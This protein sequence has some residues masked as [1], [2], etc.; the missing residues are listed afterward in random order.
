MMCSRVLKDE[1]T[2][3]HGRSTW[4]SSAASTPCW[5]AIERGLDWVLAPPAPDPGRL[6]RHAVA[7]PSCCSSSSPKGFF[8]QQDTGVIVRR[9]RGRAGH[10]LRRDAK[11]QLAQWPRSSP[12]SRHRP[13]SASA[14]AARSTHEQRPL[15]HRPETAGPARGHR[16]RDHRPP[17]PKAGGRS[18]HRPVHAS[19]RRTSTS[20]AASPHPIPIHLAGRRSRR[21]ERAGR[22]RCWRRCDSCRSCRTSPPTSRSTAPPS[23]LTIDRDQA[24]RFGIQPQLIDDTL[25]DA[26]GQ[27]QVTQ[28]FTQLN[29]YH[30]V[31]EVA[32]GDAG[33]PDA[34]STRSTSNR[35]SPASRCRCRPS[36]VRHDA[37]QPAVGQ[38]PG[39]VPGG[40][41][42]LQSGGRASRSAK[43]STPSSR[44]RR[45]WA[46]RPR[47]SAASR[48]RRR[49]S[50]PRWRPSPI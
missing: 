9:H 12:G 26:F 2:A 19:R 34:R 5:T 29:S 25:Y 45:R 17:A 39:P 32:A 46:C 43:P 22:P 20:A 8:P 30:V 27:R 16:R 48:A 6:R 4:P 7:S 33:R 15:L 40:D 1:H 42:V 31:M 14:S 18:R 50:R 49:P 23:T 41:A 28:Y 44:P 37:G 38:P 11:T 13:A 24:A 36:S 47:W 21:T 3:K 35:R 10:L